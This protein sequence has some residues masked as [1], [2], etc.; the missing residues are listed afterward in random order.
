MDVGV[1]HPAGVLFVE[2]HGSPIRW[3]I[4]DW[5][6]QLFAGVPLNGSPIGCCS[7]DWKSQLARGSP[8]FISSCGS[9]AEVRGAGEFDQRATFCLRSVSFPARLEQVI[10]CD[11]VESS[12]QRELIHYYAFIGQTFHSPDSLAIRKSTNDVNKCELIALD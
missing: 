8:P 4:E 9:S 7:D 5:E 2:R 3:C 6:S 11:G 1:P 12:R 10:C